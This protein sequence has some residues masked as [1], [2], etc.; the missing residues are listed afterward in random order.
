MT[1][2]E[3]RNIIDTVPF[4]QSTSAQRLGMFAHYRGC[5]HCQE[6]EA[7]NVAR[8]PVDPALRTVVDAT[9]V[10]DT[11]PNLPPRLRRV[12]ENHV[13]TGAPLTPEARLLLAL[14]LPDKEPPKE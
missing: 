13:K 4:N 12:L 8:L 10:L 14:E 7:K 5:A 3:F 11:M 6:W 1:C 2:D 9:T